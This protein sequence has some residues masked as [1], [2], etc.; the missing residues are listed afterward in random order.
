MIALVT[1]CIPDNQESLRYLQQGLDKIEKSGF[2]VDTHRINTSGLSHCF[3]YYSPK[4]RGWDI[5]WELLTI[6]LQRIHSDGLAPSMPKIDVPESKTD[7]QLTEVDMRIL[8][9]IERGVASVS[10][11]RSSLRIGQHRVADRLRELRKKG[12]I[13]KTWEAHN[14]GLSEH[15]FVHSKEREVG[16]TIAAW[17]LRLPRCIVS[18]SLED[19]LMLLA[20]LP[21][22]GSYGLATAIE[23]IS[24][25]CSFGIL[26]SELYG[27]W[28]FPSAL[29]D[30]RFQKWTC[31]KKELE[32][33]IENL[34]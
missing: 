27:S 18:F 20:D 17:A 12:I 31:P 16:K 1:L 15:V 22:G 19:E 30:S 24:T 26:S 33:W 10:K 5:P 9:C 32:S 4:A 11:I 23:A 21:R 2:V 8:D 3:D 29:W 28:G 6:H 7:V 25:F 14:I 34:A 13:K